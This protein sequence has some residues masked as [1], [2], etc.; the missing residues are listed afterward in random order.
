MQQRLRPWTVLV[1]CL[2]SSAAI[3]Q[4][5]T[6]G[7]FVNEPGAQPGYTFIDCLRSPDL[8]LID[9]E[10][11]IVNQ[12]ESE[13]EAGNMLY[14]LDNGSLLR[15]A[16]PGP[17][18]DTEIVEPG[19]GGLIERFNWE[20]E[21]TWSF[22]YNDP[23]VRQHHD[24]EPMPNGNVLLIAWEHH[25]Y[26][27]AISMGRN[28]A[29]MPGEGEPLYPVQ[30]AE[31][32]RTGPE[33]GEVVWSWHAWDHLVQ[34]FDPDAENH[35][36]PADHPNR[37]D[38]NHIWQ[39]A[40]DWLHCNSI[41]YNE[42]LDQIVISVNR[43]NEIWIIDHGTST[44][45]AAGPAGDLLYRWGNPRTYGHGTVEDQVLY[46]QHDAQWIPEGSPGAGSISI[47]NN[48]K[49]R[50]EGPFSTVEL[51]EPPLLE[52]GSYHRNEGEPYGPSEP[53]LA[54]IYDPPED[55]YSRY[56]S[57]AEVQPNGN[58]LACA[59]G[60]GHLV[61][62]TPE[63]EV[64]WEYI[65][66]STADGRLA[67]GEV[68]NSGVFVSANQV[69]RGPRYP[70]DHPAFEGRDM[71]P[72]EYLV[73]YPPCPA[74]IDGDRMVDGI[75]LAYLLAGWKSQEPDL[76]DDGIVDGADLTILL[77]AWGACP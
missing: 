26:E 21:K 77:A 24:I 5:Q 10:G 19:D 27:E 32:H 4:E 13:F 18:N 35:G 57:G 75:D 72:G 48:G 58:I 11:R 23:Q 43:F 47:F 42:E 60:W 17:L 12:W 73:I 61:E 36:D 30:I 3:A 59:A 6:L 45:E 50:P 38:L 44:K 29:T 8:Y 51:I 52:D 7:V 25:T 74:S 1:G 62:M 2:C 63:G 39:P 65:S 64:V 9:L 70:P 40:S 15:A 69:F 41:D 20:G 22:V 49:D 37:I 53:E 71:S 68:P 56:L 46:G 28:P 16:D 54:F 14:L 67:Q 31:V 66:P 55:F 76:N 33:S 34:D